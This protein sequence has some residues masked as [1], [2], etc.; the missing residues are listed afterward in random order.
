MFES[1]IYDWQDYQ[2]CRLKILKTNIIFYCF[3]EISPTFDW[4]CCQHLM[5]QLTSSQKNR[6]W[7][8]LSCWGGSGYWVVS[9][10]KGGI[11]GGFKCFFMCFRFYKVP[12]M[13]HSLKWVFLFFFLVN[14][15]CFLSWPVEIEALWRVH[16]EEL[17]SG[18]KPP[19][20]NCQHHFGV[21][22]LKG[23]QNGHRWRLE[24]LNS[25]W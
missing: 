25:C 8:T 4:T 22:R 23:G 10:E 19:W 20:Q 12:L 21:G 7:T 15:R 24:E 3:G 9:V 2:M 16:A 14:P 18:N 6:P 11:E 1:Q 13:T 17:G 5:I